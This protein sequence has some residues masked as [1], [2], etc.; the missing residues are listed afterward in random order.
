MVQPDGRLKLIDFGI[1]RHFTPGKTSDTMP[2]GTPGYAAPEQYGQGQTDARSDIYALGV[3]IHHLLTG[4]EPGISPFYLPDITTFPVKVSPSVATAVQQAVQMDAIKRPS[5]AADFCQMLSADL[6]ITARHPSWLWFASSLVVLFIVAV[7][8]FIVVRPQ[9]QG[10][11]VG[12]TNS[13]QITDTMD[14]TPSRNTPIPEREAVATTD[15]M[16]TNAGEATVTLY[17]TPT[18]TLPATPS[19]TLL[20]A[21]I[22]VATFT[23]ELVIAYVSLPLTTV[24]NGEMDFNSP[25]SG[26]V[27]LQN[28][29]F[30]IES[31]IF[32]SQASSAPYNTAPTRAV[33]PADM[34]RAYRLYLLLNAGNG[35]LQFKDRP[36]GR[37][38]VVCNETT[39]TASDLQLGREIREWH[40]A[41]NVVSSASR[42]QQVWQGTIAGHSNLT[43]QIDMLIV[44]LPR[45]CQDDRLTA[46][47]LV[48][49]SVE[50]VQSLD[51]AL[52]LI[53]ITVEHYDQP[54]R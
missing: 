11:V 34:A 2:F 10:K 38:N 14:A 26:L 13:Q 9:Q 24:A 8:L 20:P 17:P 49:T 28:I 6:P 46:I 31:H 23:P 42:V 53:A 18:P 1:A 51:P 30:Q 43:G 12:T 36:I 4:Y 37:L 39:Y 47:E 48:D 54:A 19:P 45:A 21:V 5:S 52:N 50:S 15:D 27:T 22:A 33:L 29:P 32:K 3:V 44:D 25:P 16:A 41:N 35:F 40:S 7:T